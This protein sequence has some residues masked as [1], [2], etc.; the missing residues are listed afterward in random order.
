MT[1]TS[2]YSSRQSTKSFER[3]LL[4]KLVLGSKQSQQWEYFVKYHPKLKPFQNKGWPLYDRM[5]EIVPAKVSGQ[6]VF[7]AS[8]TS[9]ANGNNGTT[10]NANDTPPVPSTDAESQIEPVMDNEN[11]EDSQ[12]SPISPPCTPAL[13]A[14]VAIS[15]SASLGKRTSSGDFETPLGKRTKVTGPEAILSM[16]HSVLSISDA[17][18]DAFGKKGEPSPERKA[19]ATE[20]LRQDEGDVFTDGLTDDEK[21]R[22]HIL[23]TRDVTAADA[24]RTADSG[25]RLAVARA[26]LKSSGILSNF[27]TSV[28]CLLLLPNFR[29]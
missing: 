3:L 19:K 27:I 12:P 28:L 23:F 1:H 14:P 15:G 25:M 5:G 11:A 20:M 29:N 21:A 24:Y 22:L 17:I 13:A 26:L 8:Q 16:S 18:R 4:V 7:N 6:H 2:K 9:A 10:P